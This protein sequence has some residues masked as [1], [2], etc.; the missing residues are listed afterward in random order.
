MIMILFFFLKRAQERGWLMLSEV[1]QGAS[2][3]R[4]E[5]LGCLNIQFKKASPAAS[6]LL[7]NS[8]FV[9]KAHAQLISSPF[10]TVIIHASTTSG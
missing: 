2:C 1:P 3:T 8:S 4:E 7:P 9:R 6:L 5:Y 10:F